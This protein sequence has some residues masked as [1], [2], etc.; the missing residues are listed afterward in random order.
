MKHAL[1]NNAYSLCV[2][3][4]LATISVGLFKLVALLQNIQESI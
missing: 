2:L 3:G 1:K 4:F